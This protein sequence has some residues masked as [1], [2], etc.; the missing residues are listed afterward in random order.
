MPSKP[1]IPD[2]PTK[3]VDF[4][5]DLK[6]IEAAI[7]KGAVWMDH[8][9]P[10]PDGPERTGFV[11]FLRGL[12][13]Y[14]TNG[15][16]Y[17]SKVELTVAS[18]SAFNLLDELIESIDCCISCPDGFLGQ[19]NDGDEWQV[20]NLRNPLR[21][22]IAALTQDSPTVVHNDYSITVKAASSDAPR[23]ECAKDQANVRSEVG[24]GG[25]EPAQAQPIADE[26][27][28]RIPIRASKAFAQYRDAATAL[29]KSKPEDREAYEYV[30]RK[31]EQEETHDE[32]PA[33]A[34]W[35]RNL[36]LY[37]QST[38]TQKRQRRAGR[39]DNSGSIVKQS[40]L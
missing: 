39:A 23:A 34:T 22:V 33:F 9:A 21:D 16:G 4:L 28:Q 35:S 24:V 11:A 12:K 10:V 1:D 7:A 29:D 3:H 20:D 31:C 25:I 38:N 8:H 5:T 40:D 30:A 13:R 6:T 14:T 15:K 36:R 2:T 32:L 19:I 27:K 37:R 18:D 26:R 17:H